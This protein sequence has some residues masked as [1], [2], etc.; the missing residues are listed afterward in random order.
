L[1]S[2][3]GIAPATILVSD[4]LMTT[5]SS[6]VSDTVEKVK[7]IAPLELNIVEQAD[8]FRQMANS[9][10]TMG[11]RKDAWDYYRR[12]YIIAAMMHVDRAIDYNS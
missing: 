2:Q 9:F 5:V 3:N 7:Q 8:L 6:I 12:A 4:T 1:N 10:V 11:R